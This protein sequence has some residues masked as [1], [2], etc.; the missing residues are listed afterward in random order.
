MFMTS[1]KITECVK[2]LKFKN[3]KGYDRIPQWVLIDGL[4]VIF[5]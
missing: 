1:L 4:D 3:T 2:D 5:A